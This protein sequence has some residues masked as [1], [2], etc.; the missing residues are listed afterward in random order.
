L[1]FAHGLEIGRGEQGTI[2]A[3]GLLQP[4]VRDFAALTVQRQ[5]DA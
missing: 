5:D 2:S 4:P 3:D 1:S